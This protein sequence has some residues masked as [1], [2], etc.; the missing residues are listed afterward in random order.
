MTGISNPMALFRRLPTVPA[1]WTVDNKSTQPTALLK[2]AALPA[3]KPAG[4]SSPAP[5]ANAA[6]PGAAAARALVFADYGKGRSRSV[7]D[8]SL[9]LDSPAASWR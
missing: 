8:D 4:Q 2:A 3:G 9:A 7:L 6:R 5:A 1:Q